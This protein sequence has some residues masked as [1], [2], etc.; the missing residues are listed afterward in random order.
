MSGFPEDCLVFHTDGSCVAATGAF[1]AGVYFTKWDVHDSYTLRIYTSVFQVEIFAILT[2]VS[3]REVTR[4]LEQNVHI[5]L[6]V[7]YIQGTV[8]NQGKVCPSFQKCGAGLERQAGTKGM[9]F[10]LVPNHRERNGSLSC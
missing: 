7:R 1:S 3:K 4:R 6:I 10:V 9:G 2:R 5:C 8:R